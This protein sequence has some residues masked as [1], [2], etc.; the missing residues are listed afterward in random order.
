[1][2]QTR[3]AVHRPTDPPDP[4]HAGEP[5]VGDGVPAV[6]GRELAKQP[7]LPGDLEQLVPAQLR[8]AELSAQQLGQR[9]EGQGLLR[10]GPVPDRLLG[11]VGPGRP[12]GRNLPARPVQGLDQPLDPLVQALERPRVVL[13]LGGERLRGRTGDG[14][15]QVH[16]VH[17]GVRGAAV[18][19]RHVPPGPPN[20][21]D[22][23]VH[24]PALE[25]ARLRL[26]GAQHERVQPGLVDDGDLLVTARGVDSSDT[27]LVVVEHLAESV[28][29]VRDV[30]HR[31]DVARHPPRL[32]VDREDP[33][34]LALEVEPGRRVLRVRHARPNESPGRRK[35]AT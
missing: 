18:P 22:H 6:R 25:G 14:P 7:G 23:L 9:V 12:R 15:E 30:Q 5:R 33:Y 17:R 27:L 20:G 21:R 13:Q 2:A 35:R 4:E 31:T 10:D 19:V 16:H 11:L 3:P 28:A 26:P 34:L 29:R 32:A 1:M 8:A 24:Q